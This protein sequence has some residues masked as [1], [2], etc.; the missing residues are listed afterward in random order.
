[1]AH[2][3]GRYIEACDSCAP[4]PRVACTSCTFTG[5][6]FVAQELFSSADACIRLVVL[7][8]RSSSASTRHRTAFHQHP[9]MYRINSEDASHGQTGYHQDRYGAPDAAAHRNTGAA[10]EEYD[11]LA[12][13]EDAVNGGTAAGSTYGGSQA[14]KRS[15]QDA[16]LDHGDRRRPTK[17]LR[18]EGPQLVR[19]YSLVYPLTPVCMP[20]MVLAPC[21][22]FKST[23]HN[24]LRFSHRKRALTPVP[25]PV[26]LVQHGQQ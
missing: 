8:V 6:D 16:G 3:A 22:F 5:R 21:I 14:A 1:M 24:A 25:S 23:H 10:D 13:G 4:S 12:A 7:A 18:L 17:A 11:P 2:L 15:A 9:A 26:M 20:M 19:L